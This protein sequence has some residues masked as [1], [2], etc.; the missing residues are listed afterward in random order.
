MV[1]G[2]HCQCL[3]NVVWLCNHFSV[4]GI[5]VVARLDFKLSRALAL[6]A[7]VCSAPSFPDH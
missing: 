5:V 7:L 3:Y 6:S 1:G 4:C 2:M